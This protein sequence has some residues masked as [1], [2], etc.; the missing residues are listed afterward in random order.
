[1]YMYVWVCL[2]V[3]S[4]IDF[5]EFYNGWWVEVVMDGYGFLE[6]LD[7]CFREDWLF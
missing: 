7:N 2:S 4:C 6:Y 5:F 1:M 3:N